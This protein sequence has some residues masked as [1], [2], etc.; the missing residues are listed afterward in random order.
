MFSVFPLQLY[1]GRA[2]PPPNFRPIFTFQRQIQHIQETEKLTISGKKILPLTIHC[3]KQQVT[4]HPVQIQ[5][6]TKV[7]THDRKCVL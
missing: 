3:A 4:N 7:L 1:Y 5:I 2:L 6:T